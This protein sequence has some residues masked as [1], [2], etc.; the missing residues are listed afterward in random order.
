MS[1]LMWPDKDP[2]EVLDYKIDWATRLDGDTISSS[3]WMVSAGLTKN[4][5]TSATTSTTIWLSSG[6][7]GAVYQIV[8]EIVTVGGRT[9]DQTVVLRITTK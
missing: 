3:T 2:D 1:F 9:M 5:D 6:V 7:E 4:S 8:N